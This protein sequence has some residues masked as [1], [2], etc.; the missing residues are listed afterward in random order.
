MLEDNMCHGEEKEQ[1]KG[2]QKHW[3]EEEVFKKE[4]RPACSKNSKNSFKTWA[5]LIH[6]VLKLKGKTISENL[7]SVN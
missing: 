4:T 3:G 7:K 6:L 2:N 5:E 1:Y